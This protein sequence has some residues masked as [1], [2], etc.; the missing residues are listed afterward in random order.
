M[1]LLKTQG[2]YSTCLTNQK[3]K[4]NYRKQEVHLK[5]ARG[6][7]AILRELEEVKEGRPKGSGTKEDLVKVANK[8]LIKSN[9]TTV[10]LK[11]EEK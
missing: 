10:I 7:L 4:R 3:N 6:Q 11:P 1:P 2:H 5:L 8:Y 9:S